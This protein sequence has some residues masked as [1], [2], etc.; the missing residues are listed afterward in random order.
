MKGSVLLE[1]ILLN[2]C[3]GLLA[4][5]GPCRGQGQVDLDDTTS[6]SQPHAC[7]SEQATGVIEFY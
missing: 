5:L 7:H 2:S 4:T 3:F 1:K 6:P